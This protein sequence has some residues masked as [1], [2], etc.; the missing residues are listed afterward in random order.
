MIT[1]RE[2]MTTKP[3]T[4]RPGN[5]MADAQR[6]MAE[7]HVRHIPIVDD[8]NRLVGLVSERDVLAADL[9][10]VA[11]L[12]GPDRAGFESAVPLRD[13]MT[14]DVQVVGT[15]D[16]LRLAALRLQRQKI[17]CLPVVDGDTLTGII[18]DYDFVGVAIDLIEQ[19]ELSEPEEE[20]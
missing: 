10:R 19:L 14:K 1:I 13:V 6:L 18:T 12:A 11:P 7:H 8:S 16:S 3:H 15:N 2:V 17:G 9:S 5:T 4:L 20:S